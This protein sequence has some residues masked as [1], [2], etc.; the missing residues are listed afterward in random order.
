ML[1]AKARVV[2]AELVPAIVA[3]VRGP[4]GAGALL[5]NPRVT[6][7]E[8]D[9][10]LILRESAARFDAVLLDVDNG[11]T[12]LTQA[13]NHTLYGREGLAVA[14]RSLRPG[15]RLAVWSTDDDDAFVERARRA[16]FDMRT[17]H[18]RA[19]RAGPGARG[20][21]ARHTLFVGAR[22]G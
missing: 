13:S 10:A 18:V 5:D 11:P 16:G 19:H 22:R 14:A 4:V 9:C 7:E 17:I 12:A 20:R 3:W 21:G 2:V 6:V 8:R 15:G 1:P